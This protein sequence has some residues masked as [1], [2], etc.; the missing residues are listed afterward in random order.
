[1]VD[2]DVVVSKKK[3]TTL[4]AA[5]KASCGKRES[6]TDH[7]ITLAEPKTLMKT[8]CWLHERARTTGQ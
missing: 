8:A 4:E 5:K 6:R 1:V 3:V 2:D 7:H